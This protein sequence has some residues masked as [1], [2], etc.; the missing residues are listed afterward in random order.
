M[1]NVRIFAETPDVGSVGEEYPDIVQHGGF[2]DKGDIEIHF[3]VAHS[4]GEC[5]VPHEL[6]VYQ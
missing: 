1:A 6:A 5:F 3:R 4:D 2:F